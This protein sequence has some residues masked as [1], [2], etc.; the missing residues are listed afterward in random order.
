MPEQR[1]EQVAGDLGSERPSFRT[2]ASRTTKS[3]TPPAKHDPMTIQ[4]KPGK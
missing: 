1:A 3:W 4:Q 2:E